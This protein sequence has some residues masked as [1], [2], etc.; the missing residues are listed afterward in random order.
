[1]V[2]SFFKTRFMG[3]NMNFILIYARMLNKFKHPL[4]EIPFTLTFSHKNKL[5][6]LTILKYVRKLLVRAANT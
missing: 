1:M 5:F 6:L 4:I 3:P 2:Q